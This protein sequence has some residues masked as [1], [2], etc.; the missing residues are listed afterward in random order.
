[1]LLAVISVYGQADDQ[2]IKLRNEVLKNEDL[3][4]KEY[5]NSLTKYD[6]G[7]LWTKTENTAVFGFIGENYQRLRIKI[8]SAVKAKNNPDIYF[9][10]GK[11]MVKNNICDFSGTIKIIKARVYKNM[12]LGVDDEYKNKGMRKQGIIIAEYNFQEDK[13]QQHSGIFEGVLSS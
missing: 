12:H 6:F 1:M 8:I 2:A 9:I 3:S 4:S 7:S 11:S 10:S 13:T 5:K